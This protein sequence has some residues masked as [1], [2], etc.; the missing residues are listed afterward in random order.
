MDHEVVA[1]ARDRI[2]KA[3]GKLR[4]QH[5]RNRFA[6]PL[7]CLSKIVAIAAALRIDMA[8]R[9]R[10]HVGNAG[11]TKW[12]VS[13]IFQECWKGKSGIHRNKQNENRR[14]ALS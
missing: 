7:K 5:R 1:G 12:V 13:E 3:V 11:A 14:K 4:P 8:N 10:I 9:T 6:A 2:G